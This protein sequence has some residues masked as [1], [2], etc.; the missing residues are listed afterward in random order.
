M[1]RKE[2]LAWNEADRADR[3]WGRELTGEEVSKP[4]CCA[5]LANLTA[6]TP[7]PACEQMQ[8]ITREFNYSESTFLTAPADRDNGGGGR[9]EH[10]AAL[11]GA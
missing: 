5:D 11:R 7:F 10:R 6:S 8:A 2:G 4:I 1:E 3:R 9:H